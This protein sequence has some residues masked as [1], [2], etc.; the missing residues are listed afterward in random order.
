MTEPTI[1]IKTIKKELDVLKALRKDLAK[2]RKLAAD[3]RLAPN[4][5]AKTEF[6]NF[7][8]SDKPHRVLYQMCGAVEETAAKYLDLL[9]NRKPDGEFD[10]FDTWVNKA[11]SWIG[12]TNP[13][14]ADAKGRYCRCGEDFMRA[15]DER[16]F[17]VRFWFGEG[18]QT[19]AEQRKSQR[20]TKKLLGTA[21]YNARESFYGV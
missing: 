19:A 1:E 20:Q 18:G 16:A 9:P 5:D 8:W 13:L 17:P 3:L 11:T 12:G 6:A 4:G 14:C 15:R 10:T 2:L 21:K 7:N